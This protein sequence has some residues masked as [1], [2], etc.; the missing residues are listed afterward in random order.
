MSKGLVY[1]LNLQRAN[2]TGRGLI[3]SAWA[4][5]MQHCFFEIS[6]AR[7]HEQK[8]YPYMNRTVIAGVSG[9]RRFALVMVLSI[10]ACAMAHANHPVSDLEDSVCGIVREPLAFWQFRQVAGALDASRIRSI[11]NIERLSFTTRD[12]RE[13]GG[14]KLR[15]DNPQGYLLVAQG[16]AVL[17]DQI[18][19]VLT[20]FQGYGLD[21]Y[22]YDYR[23]YGLSEGKSRLKAIVSDYRE[24]VAALNAQGYGRRYLYGMSMGGVILTN[25]IGPSEE[26]DALVLDSPPSRISGLG[27]PENY[28]PVR[29]LPQDGAKL[30]LIIGLKDR[31]VPPEDI[32]ELSQVL[33]QRGGRVLKSPEFAHPLMDLDSTILRRR[34]QSVADFLVR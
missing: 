17:A 6:T 27:C 13:L 28:D 25:A 3:S 16:N 1:P 34:L 14:Y 19:G 11:R 5:L 20:F 12:G 31:V 22:V 4:T 32:E 33:A 8:L 10:E 29:N 7:S 30:M 2:D 21:V 26:Y 9:I 15:A 23:G 24:I 18:M